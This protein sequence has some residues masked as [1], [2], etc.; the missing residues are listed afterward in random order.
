MCSGR[1]GRDSGAASMRGASSTITWA[2][3]PLNPNELTPAKARPVH[4][5]FETGTSTGTSLPI[6]GLICRK[7]KMRG[8]CPMPQRK[9]G[10]DETRNS[11]SGFEMPDVGLDGANDERRC[12]ARAQS[13]RQ[14]ARF[15]GV[16]EWRAGAVR[17]HIRD[18]G[19][20]DA[21][22]SPQPRELLPAAPRHW[23]P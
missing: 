11:R 17:F 4:A 18:I 7:F 2:L 8:D 23:E 15:N 9:H 5:V 13:G 19:G 6:C 1:S 14:S 10:F 16:A 12:G 3:V 22:P 20:I 21:G